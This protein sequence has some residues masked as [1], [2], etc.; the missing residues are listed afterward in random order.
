[1]SGAFSGLDEIIGKRLNAKKIGFGSA[2]Q[3]RDKSTDLLSRVTSADL[4]QFGF[5]SEFVGRLPV[6]AVFEYLSEAD[7][8]DILRNPNNPIIMGKKLDFA[9][10]GIEAKFDDG[11]LERLA[12]MPGLKIPAPG[13]WSAR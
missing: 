1:M 6:R 10:Y 8:F 3:P 9:A 7:L 5:E 2:L 4:L 13:V 12:K 11:A